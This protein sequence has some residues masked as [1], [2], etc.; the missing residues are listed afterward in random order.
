[1]GESIGSVNLKVGVSLVFAVYRFW[2]SRVRWSQVAMTSSCLVW[3]T[4]MQ[5][6]Y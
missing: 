3:C 2:R 4:L 1:M 5:K 6:R